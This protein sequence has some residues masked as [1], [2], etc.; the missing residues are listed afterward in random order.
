MDKKWLYLLFPLFFLLFALGCIPEQEMNM[1]VIDYKGKLPTY[2]DIPR[3]GTNIFDWQ[4]TS[5]STNTSSPAIILNPNDSSGASDRIFVYQ[6]GL[7]RSFGGMYTVPTEKWNFAVSG[8]PGNQAISINTTGNKL[9]LVTATTA[10]VLCTLD[11][12]SMCPNGNRLITSFAATG[13]TTEAWFSIDLA[14]E[15]VYVIGGSTLFSYNF[16]TSSL[17]QIPLSSTGSSVIEYLGFLYV[18]INLVGPKLYRYDAIT[19]TQVSA[20]TSIGA[21]TDSFF[22]DPT[23]DLLNNVIWYP[24]K[25]KLNYIKLGIT[26]GCIEVSN[27]CVVTTL[28][29]FVSG[30]GN[31]KAAI[32]IDWNNSTLYQAWNGTFY[33]I[34]YTNNAGTITAG[35]VTSID[36]TPSVTRVI[37]TFSNPSSAAISWSAYNQPIAFTLEGTG[38]ITRF[39]TNP[40]PPTIANFGKTFDSVFTATSCESL[41][42]GTATWIYANCNG[43]LIGDPSVQ[44]ALIQIP[45]TF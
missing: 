27:A 39:N 40:S 5:T 38:N 1:V 3:P 35:T 44:S 13:N 45:T 2:A 30:T 43:T 7:I 14:E 34:P 10:Y 36:I 23:I 31:Q 17:Q 28:T 15:R 21:F 18:T 24:I 12:I 22:A 8:I 25:N 26:N 9:A 42:I 16:T 6:H 41:P 4:I 37:N 20:L 19:L 33:K 29:T 32:T 11:N